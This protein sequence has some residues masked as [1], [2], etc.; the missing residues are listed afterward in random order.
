VIE[1]SEDAPAVNGEPE[2]EEEVV[3]KVKRVRGMEE[4]T[5]YAVWAGDVKGRHFHLSRRLLEYVGKTVRIKIEVV[6]DDETDSD[7]DSSAPS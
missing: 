5:G 7:E 1:I 3:G 6:H 2:D 4:G